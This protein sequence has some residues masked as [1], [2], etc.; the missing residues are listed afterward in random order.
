MSPRASSFLATALGALALSLASLAGCSS[1]SNGLGG[2]G[3]QTCA[4]AACP[5]GQSYQACTTTDPGTGACTGVSYSIGGQTFT[6]ASC[7]DC[8]EA[9]QQVAMACEGVVDDGGTGS[10]SGGGSGSSS[11]GGNGACSTPE[12]CGTGGRTYQECTDLTPDGQCQAIVYKTSD[13]HSF[14]CPGCTSCTGTAQQLANY[15]ATA[16]GDGGV[17]STSCTS[18]VPCGSS[19]MSYEEC[20]TSNTGGC[21]S[22][23]YKLSNGVA[24]TCAS[25]SDCTAAVQ[26]LDTYCQNQGTSTTTCTSW[27]TCGTSSLTYETCTTSLN[28]SCESIY[29]ETSDGYTYDCNSCGD[30]S[31]ASSSMESHCASQSSTTSCGSAT[32]CGNTGVT[33]EECETSTGGSCTSIYYSTSDGQSYYCNSCS[34]CSTASADLTSYCSSLEGQTC[35]SSTCTSGYLCCDCSGTEECLSSGGGAYT[36]SSYGCQ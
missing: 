1:A 22:I 28:G 11:G 14:T 21:E 9:A 6:C 15:C 7:G 16:P 13:G 24:Y 33:Y 32:A 4:S 31:S 12:A 5:N 36:C 10:S 34:D 8:S 30:C 27:A 20:T 35:G 23:Q 26:S 19:G 2:N 17:G 18:S 3:H 25:C 29:Y